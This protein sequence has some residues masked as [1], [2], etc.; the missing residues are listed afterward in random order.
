MENPIEF[1]NRL[2]DFIRVLEKKG[3]AGYYLARFKRV[4]RS[5]TRH[6]NINMKL[7]IT[8]QEKMSLHLLSM[9]ECPVK[10]NWERF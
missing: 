4:L 5:W 3:K 9:K 10:M 7:D 8:L 1:K 6:H 2:S